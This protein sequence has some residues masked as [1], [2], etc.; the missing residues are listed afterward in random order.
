[1]DSFTS[2]DGQVIPYQRYGG[3]KTIIF[4]HALATDWTY[5]KK[6]VAFFTRRGYGA[7]IPTLRGHS[8]E[9][10]RLKRITAEDHVKDI[11]VLISK[12]KLHNPVIVGASLGGAIAAAYCNKHPSAKC[13]CINTPFDSAPN[14]IWLYFGLAEF[15]F[16]PISV[17]LNLFK[18]RNFDYSESN[19]TN[20]VLLHFKTALTLDYKGI[21]LNYHWLRQLK[22]VKD[23]GVVKIVSKQDEVLT[24]HV[25]PDFEIDGNHHCVLSEPEVVNPLLLKIIEKL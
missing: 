11:E 19:I 12:L 21:Y 20:A 10:T 22:G 24:P 13:I 7:V 3:K 23:S 9:R 1:M 8:F 2:F 14:A 17:L 6:P 16:R 18:R 4:L 25:T 15:L 5:W